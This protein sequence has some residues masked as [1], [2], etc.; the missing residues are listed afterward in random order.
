MPD[1]HRFAEQSDQ[2]AIGLALRRGGQQFREWRDS[3]H[4]AGVKRRW[5]E[6]V[7]L[8]GGREPRPHE[9]QLRARRL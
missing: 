2:L 4:T 5:A 7:G 8:D 6:Q 9:F 1:G 3:I